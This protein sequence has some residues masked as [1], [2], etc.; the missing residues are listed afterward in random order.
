LRLFPPAIVFSMSEKIFQKYVVFSL[1]SM[2]QLP[3]YFCKV[4]RNCRKIFMIV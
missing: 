4:C 1:D 3:I 2:S